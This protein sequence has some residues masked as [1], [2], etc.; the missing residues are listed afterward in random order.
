MVLKI[1]FD[2]SDPR[3]L[4]LASGTKTNNLILMKLN[5]TV[6]IKFRKVFVGVGSEKSSSRLMIFSYKKVSEPMV[7]ES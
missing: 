5:Q 7:S 4:A 6:Q 1:A 2:E 3:V